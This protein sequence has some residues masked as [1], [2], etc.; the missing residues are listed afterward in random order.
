MMNKNKFKKYNKCKKILIINFK[1]KK[2]LK[3]RKLKDQV[4]WLD[5]IKD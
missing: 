1:L 2:E 5:Y 4:K 3:K